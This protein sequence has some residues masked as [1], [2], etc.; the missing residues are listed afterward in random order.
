[1]NIVQ[2][3]PMLQ[4]I[5]EEKTRRD[6]KRKADG[7]TST[8]RLHMAM[9][10]DEEFAAEAK[11]AQAANDGDEQDDDTP[12]KKPRRTSLNIIM[13]DA[14]PD[15]YEPPDELIEGLLTTGAGSILYGDSNAGKTFFAIDLGCAVARGEPWHDRRT[16]Q[17]TVIYLASESPRSVYSRLQAY[18]HYHQ[19]DVPN[20]AIVPEP[21]NLWVNDEDTDLLIE[22]I[23]ALVESTGNKAALIIGDTL[24]RMSAGANENSGEDMGSVI[25]RFDRI[26]HETGAHFMM[27]HHSG[28]DQSRG[29]R[30]HSSLRAAVDTEIEVQDSKDG[31]FAQVTKQRDLDGKGKRI[32]FRLHPIQIG[33]NRWN[34][35]AT[36]CVVLPADAPEKVQVFKGAQA[37]VIEHVAANPGVSKS[38]LKDALVCDYAKSAIYQAITALVDA[39]HIREETADKTTRLYR[40]LPSLG[41]LSAQST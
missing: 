6:S 35:P 8:Q 19:C 36:M 30:G 29:A 41:G 5:E 11:L 15:E 24:A 13:A 31:K 2:I 34:S 28:K 23:N 10:D 16:Q 40:E 37:K 17:G 33:A 4:R 38:D 18:K 32:G 7:Y 20:F 39:G 21:I 12:R 9:Q 26:R 27:I 14:L 3:D 25:A 22:E 1:M